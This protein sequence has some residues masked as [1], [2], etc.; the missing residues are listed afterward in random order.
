MN[1]P[2][3]LVDQPAYPPT[4][5]EGGWLLRP[6]ATQPVTAGQA[7]LA[8][9]FQ[10]A[11]GNNPLMAQACFGLPKVEFE[12]LRTVK[13]GPATP[14]HKL[15]L[16]RLSTSGTAGAISGCGRARLL[17]QQHHFNLQ[18]G[19]GFGKLIPPRAVPCVPLQPPMRRV[20]SPSIPSN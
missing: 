8:L 15:T 12:K 13:S 10:F 20:M 17:A 3:V 6:E 7:T 16:D 11:P 4:E 5:V 14:S 9:V 18:V 1:P 19:Q 2:S